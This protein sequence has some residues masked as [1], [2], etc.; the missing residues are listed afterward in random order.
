MRN[1]GPPCR[2]PCRRARRAGRDAPVARAAACAAA[3]ARPRCLPAGLRDGVRRDADDIARE[4]RLCCCAAAACCRLPRG[5]C[6]P[7]PPGPPATSCVV[8]GAQFPYYTFVDRQK[9]YSIGARRDARGEHARRTPGAALG[10]ARP[11]PETL[12][13]LRPTRVR[14]PQRHAGSLF[15]AIYFFVSFPLFM[16]L[17]EAPGGKRWSLGEVR[18]S[19]RC[20]VGA[21]CGRRRSDGG[22][23]APTAA[24]AARLRARAGRAGRARR[25]D[26]GD[27]AAGRLAPDR[28]RH[29]RLAG[30][31]R[32]AAV[33]GDDLSVRWTQLRCRLSCGGVQQTCQLR[34]RAFDRASHSNVHTRRGHPT[35]VQRP[36]PT[37]SRQHDALSRQPRAGAGRAAQQSCKRSARAGPGRA[38]GA[39]RSDRRATAAASR[40]CCCW[41][42]RG[43]GCC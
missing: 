40:S 8:H 39:A 27:A 37:H 42:G 2:A 7:S 28:R 16:R 32:G 22:S 4:G 11:A 14:A 21:A 19:C 38:V 29:R 31:V 6:R 30:G 35:R 26:A 17:D 9:M 34:A 5:S 1:L 12:P 25:G 43:W 23:G 3:R 41:P 18:A 33:G 13:R 24:A 36:A 15:Y 10:R 20:R